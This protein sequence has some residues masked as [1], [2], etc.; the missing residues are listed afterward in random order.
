MKTITTIEEDCC[1]CGTTFH[2]DETLRDFRMKD[3]GLFYCPNGHG[4]SFADSTQSK[5]DE[6]TEELAECKSELAEA[7]VEIRRL[8]C[9][10][11]AKP[12]PPANAAK[13]WQFLRLK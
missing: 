2:I 12:E 7:Q 13:W 4:Q 1:V 10:L 9:A 6:A 11:V 5:L 8:K 3:G